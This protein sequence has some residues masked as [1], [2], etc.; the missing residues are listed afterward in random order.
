MNM[1]CSTTFVWIRII[2]RTVHIIS[3]TNPRPHVC[4]NLW[5]FMTHSITIL[6]TVW[7][8]STGAQYNQSACSWL[9]YIKITVIVFSRT[10]TCKSF[11]FTF[12]RSEIVLLL[13]NVAYYVHKFHEAQLRRGKMLWLRHT[14]MM[15]AHIL[16]PCSSSCNSQPCLSFIG[17][18]SNQLFRV[19]L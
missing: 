6:W 10:D 1:H 19:E 9:Q 17:F 16:K 7:I 11:K 14:G 12:R 5:E 8:Q 13:R 4:Y 15:S 2:Q 3:S 18:T